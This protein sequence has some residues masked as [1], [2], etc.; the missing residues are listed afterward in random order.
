MTSKPIEYVTMP[1]ST[2]MA[3]ITIKDNQLKRIVGDDPVSVISRIKLQHEID[4]LRTA[5][6]TGQQV[7][8]IP[9]K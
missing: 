7:N 2:L 3:L 5:I 4:Q 9:V 1:V 8:C 6:L